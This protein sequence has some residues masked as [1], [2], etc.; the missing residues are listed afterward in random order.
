M[1]FSAANVEVERESKVGKR[2]FVCF[3]F[4]EGFYPDSQTNNPSTP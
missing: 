1:G 4:A 3:V 2:A